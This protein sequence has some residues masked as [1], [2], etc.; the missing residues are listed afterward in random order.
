VAGLPN[1][2]DGLLVFTLNPT[3]YAVTFS[4]TPASL[5]VDYYFSTDVN[6]TVTLAATIQPP[7]YAP[8]AAT[9]A[10]VTT[11]GAATNPVQRAKT[12]A[13]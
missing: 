9:P 11:A 13:N 3:T 10:V 12:L 7:L 4:T 8:T 1:V 2:Y 5:V 6:E